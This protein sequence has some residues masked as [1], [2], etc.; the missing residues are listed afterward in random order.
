MYLSIDFAM[1]MLYNQ[2]LK[3]L[4][5]QRFHHSFDNCYV[6]YRHNQN[7]FGLRKTIFEEDGALVQNILTNSL[8]RVHNH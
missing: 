6:A 2:V 8:S 4:T 5:R 1:N 7:N 3:S